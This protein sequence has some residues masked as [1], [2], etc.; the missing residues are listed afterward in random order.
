MMGIDLGSEFFKVTV[1]KPGK[2]FMMMENLVSKTKTENA[3]GLKGDEIT[4]SYDALSKKAKSPLN[5]FNYFSEYLGRTYNDSFI[6]EYLEDFYQSYNI[7]AENDTEYITFNFKFNDKNEQISIVEIYSMILDYIEFL[8][9][10]FTDIQ[11]T[12][13]FI[14]IPSFFDYQQRQAIADAIKISKLRLRGVISENLAAAVQFQ[15]KK[16]FYN[17]TFYIIYNMGSSY[18]QS[19]LISFKTIF[20]NKSVVVGNEI[21]IYGETY[22][23]KLG[24]K[25]FDNNLCKLLMKK[26]DELPIRKGKKS[27]LDNK[28]VYERIR[29]STKKYKEI[30]SA[31]KEA[32]VTIIGVEGGDNL[33]TKIT[34]EEFEE[35]N[36][37][38][39]T[40]IYNPI[41][42]L[43]KKT[44]MTINN[45]SQIELVGGSIRIPA[46]Q[47]EIKNKLG[48]YS[49]ILGI[50]MNGDDSM[51]FGAAYMCANSS[52]N[53]LGIRKTFMQ[54]GANE[55]FKAYLSNLKNK[56]IPFNYCE[57]GKENKICVKKLKIEKE[58][59]PLRHN[60]NSKSSIEIE[61][62]TNILVKITEE[63]PGKFEERD[64][65][66]FEIT[67]VPEA[68]EK[69]KKDKSSSIPKINII[70]IY[71]KEGLIKLESYIKYKYQKYFSKDF[72][73][74]KNITEPLPKEEIE[75]INEIL[76]KSIVLS[77]NDMKNLIKN[78]NEEIRK[79]SKINEEIKKINEKIEEEKEIKI[80]NRNIEEEKLV[81]SN[82]FYNNTLY[83]T[84]KEE[85]RLKKLKKIGN[86]KE[87]EETIYLKIKD[88]HLLYP[89]PMNDTQIQNS[90]KKIKRFVE[91]DTNRLKI[92]EKRNELEALIFDRKEYLY[93]K[94]TKIYLKPEEIEKSII[95]INN[96]SSWYEEDGFIA[97][98]D[99]LEIEIKNIVNYFKEYEK[100]KIKYYKMAKAINK[101]LNDL[102]SIQ[103]KHSKISKEKPWTEG[104]FNKT[105]LKELNETMEWLNLAL[106]IQ[107]NIP[108]LNPVVLKSFLLNSKMGNLYGITKKKNLTEEGEN[109]ENYKN[110]E[111]Q[112]GE[113]N[114]DDKLN[115]KKDDFYNISKED[116]EK[117]N[118]NDIIKN[119]TGSSKISKNINNKSKN[120]INDILKKIYKPNNFVLI[121]VIIFKISK[122]LLFYNYENYET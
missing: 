71:T 55:K 50:H 70:F 54:N 31:N 93:D 65:K 89:K 25:Y 112:L 68:I 107:E 28:G 106:Y 75:K 120:N 10:K 29:Y 76:N 100:R 23:E 6:K 83:I 3:L 82:Y 4:Y 60:Y 9:E 17:E 44:N 115:N 78:I 113:I 105:F 69:K 33:Y 32:F 109:K 88:I 84:K 20:N 110:K 67:G 51:A 79:K 41:E 34:R 62:D 43:L 81:P 5:I 15:L 77:E 40:K 91:I 38:L 66:Y 19:S 37:E 117:N 58:I 96:K 73:Y 8:A 7:S 97:P 101:F 42:D 95:Y 85:A 118:L 92:I 103:E 1:I 61:H 119:K 49:N 74:I 63:F 12:D 14:T 56:T 116:F 59:F 57:E 45:I 30:L 111:I 27:V 18:T 122:F 46:V 99:I 21:K 53:F 108:N 86:I 98:Y 16:V 72:Y 114:L 13:V 80:K 39:I 36:K 94:N 35:I 121:I 102:Y 87:E 48:N 52:Q 22:N 2:P 64:L 26:F 24:G 90:I 104:Y 11:M 47:K